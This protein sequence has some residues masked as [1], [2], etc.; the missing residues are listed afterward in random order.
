MPENHRVPDSGK[1]MFLKEYEKV[2]EYKAICK[3]ELDEFNKAANKLLKDGNWRPIG[4]LCIVETG[5]IR[6]SQSFALIS[7]P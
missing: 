5:G 1:I 7:K 3:S 6:F 4:G 2:V